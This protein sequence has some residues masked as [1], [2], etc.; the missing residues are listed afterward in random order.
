MSICRNIASYS[1]GA[2][3]NSTGRLIFYLTALDATGADVQVKLAACH[4][5]LPPLLNAVPIT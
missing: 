4:L 3:G 1:D 2:L 5:T